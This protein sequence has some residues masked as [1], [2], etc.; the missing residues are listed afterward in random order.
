M[1]I[2]KDKKTISI[3]AIVSPR[4]LLFEFVVKIQRLLILLIQDYTSQ[5]RSV[6]SIWS[7]LQLNWVFL[8]KKVQNLVYKNLEIQKRSKF[9]PSTMNNNRNKSE[10]KLTCRS[11]V[12]T[13]CAHISFNNLK[14]KAVH[15]AQQ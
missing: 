6:D 15:V 7:R 1:G 11:D 3:S 14:A 2:V 13:F 12:I 5:T 10:T 4:V 9:L 8:N